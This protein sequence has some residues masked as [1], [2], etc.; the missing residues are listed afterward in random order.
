MAG[1]AVEPDV[2]VV[3]E[4]ERP[5]LGSSHRKRQV[6]HRREGRVRRVAVHVAP[7]A[8][9]RYRVRMVATPTVGQCY[10]E[11]LAVRVRAG[12]AVAALEIAVLGVQETD[13]FLRR[14]RQPAHA[15]PR[16]VHRRRNRPMQVGA[17]RNLLRG[18]G[19]RQAP[20][21]V[22]R[23]HDGIARESNGRGV[24]ED[25]DVTAHTVGAVGF[26]VVRLVAHRAVVEL[27]DVQCSVEAGEGVGLF[28]TARVGARPPGLRGRLLNVWIV[29]GRALTPGA[30]RDR[31]FRPM[32]AWRGTTST[33]PDPEE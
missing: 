17:D 22:T 14:T 6:S 3:I 18:P 5:S 29:T 30:D 12:V 21:G 10:D 1:G 7:F 23:G 26:E 4:R 25:P 33:R 16:G 20:H 9:A 31:A 28:M 27:S 15:H 8:G 24:V 32:C 19:D 11:E 13:R 2:F